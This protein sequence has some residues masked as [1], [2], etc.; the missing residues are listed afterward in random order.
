MYG[1]IDEN[2]NIIYAPKDYK[3]DTEYILNFNLNEGIMK[4]HGFKNVIELTPVYNPNY[5]YITKNNP[6]DKGEYIELS[7]N[8][9][10]MDLDVL[11]TNKILESKKELANYLE[12]HPL[13]ST[14]KY[15]EGRFYNVTSEKQQQLTSKM[16]IANG[17]I[18]AGLPYTVT[19]N[20][21]GLICEPWTMAELTQ[22]SFEIDGYVTPLVKHQ[23][24]MEVEI[25]AKETAKEVYEFVISYNEVFKNK[26]QST[27]VEVDQ[28]IKDAEE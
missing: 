3:T 27:T 16:L 14:A 19:W 28:S 12:T 1:K 22:L 21:T 11:K 18:M 15:P 10:D 24:E 25:K 7:Y 6:V 26:T 8:V 23:Q 9:I 4:E 2:N 5:Q 13:Y 17:Y 20:D